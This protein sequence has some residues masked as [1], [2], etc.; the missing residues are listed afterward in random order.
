MRQ[1][2]RDF[3][4]E[5][6]DDFVYFHTL[7]TKG[8]PDWVSRKPPRVSKAEIRDMLE[9]ELAEYQATPPEDGR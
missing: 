6:R 9:A 2:L 7:V 4:R 5:I 3:L 1:S 8:N